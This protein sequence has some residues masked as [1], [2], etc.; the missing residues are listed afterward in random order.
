MN[1]N[2]DMDMDMSG[3]APNP[4]KSKMPML[5][6]ALESTSAV[7]PYETPL[8]RNG[9]IGKEFS[10]AELQRLAL[11]NNPT[12]AQAKAQIA[13]EKGKA[14]QAGLVPNPT[15]SYAADLLGVR[16]AGGGEFQ[17]AVLEQEIV[18]GGKLKYSR[19]KYQARVSAAEQQSRAQNL[20]VMNDVAVAFYRTLGA[21]ERVK[22]QQDAL[23]SAHDWWLTRR[24]MF[25][26]GEANQADIHAINVVLERQNLAAR[27]AENELRL[28]WQQLMTAVGID[29]EYAPLVGSLDETPQSVEWQTALRRLLDQS[30]ELSEAKEKLRSDE[31]TVKR[32]HRQPIPNVVLAGGPGYDQLDRSFA[33]V[34]TASV[35]NI[36]IFNRNQGTVK[37]AEADLS[38]Q[39]AQVRLIELQLRARLA[40]QFM[41]YQ[42]AQQHVDSYRRVIVPES[43]Q[44]YEVLL[45]S[46]QDSRTD[47]P[48]VLEAQRD[49]LCVRLEFVDHL[50]ELRE[51]TVE[52]EGLLLSGG[53]VPPPGVTPPG[54]ID[55]TPQPR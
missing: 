8:A 38:R 19:K 29:G 27:T 23:R 20:R 15:M 36:P 25:N 1:M 6:P 10:L 35:T 21:A 44:R 37:Q 24:E 12:V 52:I 4:E 5:K 48:Q 26:L 22:I 9:T 34:A 46:Y 55:A 14:L 41:R 33:A 3:S 45:T 40:R 53:L 54:H 47:W 43:R 13:G 30:P 11:D 7:T 50:V 42:T 49:F 39:K 32:E 31:Y 18:L 28:E 16:T 2:M 51:A 17:G